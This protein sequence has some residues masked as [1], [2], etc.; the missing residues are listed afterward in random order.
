MD[1]ERRG[2]RVIERKGER[3]IEREYEIK[4]Q[5]INYLDFIIE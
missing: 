3:A 5:K 4:E 1:V 2:D